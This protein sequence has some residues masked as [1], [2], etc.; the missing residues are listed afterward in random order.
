MCEHFSDV[1]DR[2]MDKNHLTVNDA[3]WRCGEQ[4]A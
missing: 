1:M 2:S 4:S 3:T